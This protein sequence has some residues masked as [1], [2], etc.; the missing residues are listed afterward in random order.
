MGENIGQVYSLIKTGNAELGFIARGQLK[1]TQ[2]P[3]GTIWP[4]PASL[5]RPIIQDAVIIKTEFESSGAKAFYTFLKSDRARD[6]IQ[7]A[8][9]DLPN[10]K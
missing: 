2:S 3:S 1:A 9:Y 6:I 10:A 7:S 4:V 5:H 8:G